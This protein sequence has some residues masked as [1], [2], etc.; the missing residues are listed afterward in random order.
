[1][2]DFFYVK[3][4]LEIENSKIDLIYRA[5]NVIFSYY[6]NLYFYFHKRFK[7]QLKN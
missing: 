1:M 7:K 2:R 6:E 5:K 3:I 4:Y